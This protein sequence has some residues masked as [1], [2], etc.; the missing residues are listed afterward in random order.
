MVPPA[1]TAPST[2]MTR[3]LTR[4]TKANEKKDMCELFE[5]LRQELGAAVKTCKDISEI[6]NCYI[7]DF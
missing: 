7:L 4:T 6:C 1:P 3:K 2:R 5:H